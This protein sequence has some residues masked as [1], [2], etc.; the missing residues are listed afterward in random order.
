[1]TPIFRTE[2]QALIFMIVAGAVTCA[3]ILSGVTIDIG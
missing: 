1:M 3:L 2:L